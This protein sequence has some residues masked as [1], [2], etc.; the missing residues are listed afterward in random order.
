MTYR[1][2][3]PPTILNLEQIRDWVNEELNRLSRSLNEIERFTNF[4]A[5]SIDDN[6]A[7]PALRVT[8]RGT[9]PVALFEDQASVDGSPFL[10]DSGGKIV[11]GYTQ[12]VMIGS[13]IWNTQFHGAGVALGMAIV[14]WNNTNVGAR[15]ILAKSPSNVMGTHAQ[16]VAA[17]ELG[18]IEVFASDGT[19]FVEAARITCSMDGTPGVGDMPTKWEFVVC[20]D[21]SATLTTAMT[22]KNTGAIVGS[23]PFILPTYTVAGVP[24]AATF[25]RGLAYI[26]N[27]SGGAVVAFSDGTN[28][29]RV[30]DRAVIS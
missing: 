1:P 30:T 20:P 8:Q 17:N 4:K 27:E 29:R 9:G 21:G 14:N 25:A 12:A 18:Y 7:S 3:L 5:S 22:I 24:S 26:S 23:F 28:W 13:Q 6:S 19:N 2:D 16:V 10:I 11:Q 15:V